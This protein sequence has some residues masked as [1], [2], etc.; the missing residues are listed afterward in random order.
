[1]D[2]APL[3]IRGV[4]Q[5]DGEVAAVTVNGH[6]ARIVARR[7]GVVDWEILLDPPRDGRIAARAEDRAGNE[8]Q[9]AHVIET[10]RP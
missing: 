4:S 2:A 5:D 6:P 10:R 9:T 8:E 3:L 7:A 1:M